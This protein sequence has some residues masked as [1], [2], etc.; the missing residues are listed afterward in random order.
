M[1][2]V[3]CVSVGFFLSRRAVSR[4][5]IFQFLTS[6]GELLA[7]AGRYLQSHDIWILSSC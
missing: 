6:F 7:I 1:P 3:C 5:Q 2:W 4:R